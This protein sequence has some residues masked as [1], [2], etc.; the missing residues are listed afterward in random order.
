VGTRRGVSLSFGGRGGVGSLYNDIVFGRVDVVYVL[1]VFG[2]MGVRVCFLLSARYLPLPSWSCC[3]L[4]HGMPSSSSKTNN[5]ALGE[6]ESR[7]YVGA[8]LGYHF[9]LLRS[10]SVD[11]RSRVLLVL[12]TDMPVLLRA[13]ACSCGQGLQDSRYRGLG[14]SRLLQS[15]PQ[16]IFAQNLNF[17]PTNTSNIATTHNPAIHAYSIIRPNHPFPSVI[18]LN[19]PILF[20]AAS[21]PPA[22]LSKPS[23]AA[24]RTAVSASREVENA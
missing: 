21:M 8:R 2:C 18:L 12:Q 22:F 10:T 15:F 5:T 24:L 20:P 14:P 6:G 23:V 17:G 19:I 7:A 9:P 16:S 1:A 3:A 11:S 4:N 13:N